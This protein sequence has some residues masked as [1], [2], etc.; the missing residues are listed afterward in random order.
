MKNPKK[1]ILMLL[2]NSGM[3]EDVR[4][5]NEAV[6]LVENGF[7][8]CVICPNQ[9]KV[10]RYENYKGVHLYRYPA[11]AEFKGFWGYVFE[12]GYSLIMAFVYSLYVLFR[13]GFHVVHVHAPPDLNC[14]VAI[15]YK[16][17]FFKKFVLDTHDLSPE[18]YNAQNGGQGNRLV[19]KTLR[20]IE[21]MAVRWSDHL[22][23]TN[24]SQQMI[25][26]KRC[27]KSLQ[28]CCIVR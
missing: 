21:R 18:L 15:F 17:F 28:K 14:F 20:S 2:E 1:K 24:Q 9:K 8:V 5:R 13:R 19:Y 12:F 10:Q 7:E 27:G 11:P 25:Q 4:V 22:I 23:T 16:L 6:S 3:P 26:S